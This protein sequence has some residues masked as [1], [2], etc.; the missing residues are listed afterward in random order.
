MQQSSTSVDR[1]P[2]HK[3]TNGPTTNLVTA[4][5]PTTKGKENP[6]TKPGVGKCYKCG[7]SGYKSNEC[8][9]RREVNTADYEDE[10]EVKIEI[11]L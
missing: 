6:Y 5:A 10:D 7:E 11:E 1:P 4:V 8:P 3:A 9:R 2:A